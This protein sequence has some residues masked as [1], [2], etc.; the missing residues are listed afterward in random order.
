MSD[1]VSARKGEQD[2]RPTREAAGAPID[3]PR[4]VDLRQ[5]ERDEL[6]SRAAAL[7]AAEAELRA[8]LQTAHEQL[9]ARDTRIAEL[10]DEAAAQREAHRAEMGGVVHRL[11]FA[12]DAAR[13]LE[14]QLDDAQ[15]QIEAMKTTRAWRIVT[16]VWRF[17]D[18]LRRAP[19]P[20][21]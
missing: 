18:R 19:A 11:E 16:A 10:Q 7:A 8:H 5:A 1:D 2:W 20:H 4:A 6:A 15:Q 3:R 17:R 13:T 21:R 12:E 14:A 9:A